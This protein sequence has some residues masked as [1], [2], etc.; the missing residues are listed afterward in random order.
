MHTSY[1]LFKS[2]DTDLTDVRYLCGT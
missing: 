1:K 2:G